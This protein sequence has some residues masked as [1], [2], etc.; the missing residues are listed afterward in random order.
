MIS[1]QDPKV[2]SAKPMLNLGTK[3]T[4]L[5]APTQVALLCHESAQMVLDGELFPAGHSVTATCLLGGTN[6]TSEHALRWVNSSGGLLD[7]NR[8]RCRCDQGMKQGSG[9]T[10]AECLPC[11]DG[12]Y[13]PI[14]A[15]GTRIECRACPREGVNCNDGILK[16][17]KDMW[18]D[19]KRVREGNAQGQI[20]LASTTKMY[21]CAMRDACLIDRSA[22][23][24]TVKCHEN[25]TG[26]MCASCYNRRVDCAR[27]DKEGKLS[28][29][30]IAVCEAPGYFSR[31]SEWMFFAPIARH[32]IRCPAG[33]D[34][35][36][37]YV[38]L[39]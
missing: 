33:E 39:S 11:A 16:I 13:A 21:A 15:L 26:V 1:S 14:N 32:C 28:E 5:Q 9:D 12:T 3:R 38:Q 10:V 18:Y 7:M 31:D 24:M 19:A 4:K 8:I 30:E 20:G 37:S 29:A 2:S 17:F 6:S 25:H 27:E 23:P 34:A 22:V 35:W 36:A